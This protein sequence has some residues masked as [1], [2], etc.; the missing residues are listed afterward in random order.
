MKAQACLSRKSEMKYWYIEWDDMRTIGTTAKVPWTDRELIV[1]ESRHRYKMTLE[2]IGREMGLTRERIRQI[3]NKA[4][5][6]VESELA[7][8]PSYSELLL[9]YKEG[10]E[11]E[12]SDTD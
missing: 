2:S 4:L 7:R 1:M 8:L 5:R 6:K 11:H 9:K 10:K 3:E 12:Q